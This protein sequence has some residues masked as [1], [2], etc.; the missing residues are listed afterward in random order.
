MPDSSRSCTLKSEYAERI[1][2]SAG[3]SHSSPLVSTKV[4]PVACS[5][6]LSTL[7]LVTSELSR[8]EKFV[9]RTRTG[10]IVVCGLALEELAQPH[11]S[12]KPQ[13]VQGPR[14]SPRGLV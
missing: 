4:T 7:I 14:R 9:L 12:Q 5:P 10:R 11:H 3:C 6:D 8:A 1:T 2:R 13:Y